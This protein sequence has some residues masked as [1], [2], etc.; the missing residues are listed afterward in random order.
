MT[1]SSSYGFNPNLATFIDE[2]VENA[3]LSPQEINGDHITSIRRS[4][5]FAFA[6]WANK[7]HRE[8][9]FQQ[10]VHTVTQGESAFNL[11]KGTIDVQTI[12]LRRQ[13]RDTGLIPASRSDYT[14][15]ADKTIQGR[16]DRYYVD[17]R[18]DDQD[19]V[20]NVRIVYW[21]LASNST[22][23]IVVDLWKQAEDAGTLAST[24]DMPFRFL[25]AFQWEVAWRTAIK[26]NV[27]KADGLKK[28]ADEAWDSSQ[29]EDR[30]PAPFVMS[31]S[32]SRRHG[33]RR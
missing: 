4:M 9:K 32:Y 19:T 28:L 31:V 17:R 21:P 11:P 3:G 1:T 10:F 5:G 2:A 20:S 26:F 29:E 27:K 7:G 18:R 16:P 14:L 13:D 6:R 33:R 25:D 15:L 12:I 23:Q 22:D 8:W 30:D 24:M